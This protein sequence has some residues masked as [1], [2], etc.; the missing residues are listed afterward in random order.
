M[1]L[2]NLYKISSF[3]F[4]FF[5][6]FYRHLNYFLNL[7]P[8]RLRP[9]WIL[10][11]LSLLTGLNTCH[12]TQSPQPI[13]EKEFAQIYAEYLFIVTSDTANDEF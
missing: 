6:T 13:S 9:V 2:K 11:I 7:K 4:F 5:D 8:S 1:I 10:L 12:Q 3:P